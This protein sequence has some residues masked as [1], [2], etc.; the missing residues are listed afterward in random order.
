[1]YIQRAWQAF[2][3]SW[4]VPIPE[5]CSAEYMHTYIH[6]FCRHWLAA[7][8]RRKYENGIHIQSFTRTYI[9][10][11]HIHSLLHAFTC[12]RCEQSYKTLCTTIHTYIHTC[13]ESSSYA[14]NRSRQDGWMSRKTQSERNHLLLGRKGKAFV[15]NESYP[16]IHNAYTYTHTYIHTPNETQILI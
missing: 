13:I 8:L 15:R 7:M 14:P 11:L 12:I 9:H 4:M 16:I 10:L 3:F 5:P 2:A 1:L 6:S